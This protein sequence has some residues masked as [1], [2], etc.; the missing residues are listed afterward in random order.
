MKTEYFSFSGLNIAP[1]EIE[2]LMGFEPEQA[3][4]PFP[5]L[6]EDGLR[7]A[8]KYCQI[9]GGYKL[10]N[11]FQVD[12]AGEIMVVEDQ[13][14]HPGRIVVDRLKKATGAALF[15]CTAG[16]GISEYARKKSMEGDEMMAYVLDVIGSATVDKAAGVLQE[17][18]LEEVSGSGSGISDAFSPG[19]CNW[20]VAEQQKL[21]SL[22]PEGFCNIRLSASSLMHPVKS[23]S[24]ITGIGI[25][26]KRTGYQCNWCNDRDCIYGKIR[27]NKKAKKKL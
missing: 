5:E 13:E 27:R 17:R 20:S 21:F 12:V 6:I 16:P 3:P 24:G 14:F 25:A 18:I 23:V 8:P 10:F 15:L 26:C 22:L 1:W 11:K 9:I 7:Q 4:A 19:Y 2:E